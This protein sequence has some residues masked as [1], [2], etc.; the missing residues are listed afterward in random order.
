MRHMIYFPLAKINLGLNVVHK[1]PDGYHD[2]E[3][4][5]YPVAIRDALEVLPMDPQFP[6]AVACDLKVTNIS[7]DGEDQNNLVVKAYNQLAAYYDLPRVH[8]H[9]YKSIPTQAGMG[10]GSSDCAYM[11]L[12]LNEMFHLGM[13]VE[14]MIYHAARLGADCPFFILSRPAYAEGIG[15]CLEP[16]DLSLKGYWLVVV[17]PDIPI[18]T[19]EAFSLIKPCPTVKKCCEVIKQPIC[20]W[21]D[22]LTN[23]FEKSVFAIHP[24][25]GVIKQ[26]LYDCGAIYSAMSGS[27]SCVFGIFDENIDLSSEF[28]GM[29]CRTVELY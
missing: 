15:E 11:I 1:R 3:T 21:R 23:D 2:L 17:Q 28:E 13:S 22:E 10:G 16:V 18:S 19:R 4:V 12:A 9:L 8:A 29:F 24:E 14:E 20:T 27:G 5:F 7:I 25:I 6:S 26:R